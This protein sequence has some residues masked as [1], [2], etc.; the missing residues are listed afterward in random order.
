MGRIVS[1]I[2]VA[3]FSI[4]AQAKSIYP[5]NPDPRLTP[6]SVCK[7]AN[8]YRYPERIAYCNRN[9]DKS[10]K[11]QV[12]R[13]YEQQLGYRID[14]GQRGSFKIDHLIPL[15]A[16]GSN[17]MDNLW[18][19]HKTVYDITDPMEPLICEKMAEGR[20]KQARAIELIHRAKNDLSQV[21]QV[22]AE[23]NSL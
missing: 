2:L 3:I 17:E 10:E 18:P 11:Q 16:G 13:N 8:Y 20:L 5:K 23:L 7:Q 21:P 9:V 6:G 4:S 12:I 14:R 22:M 19:Q 1:F 15:C